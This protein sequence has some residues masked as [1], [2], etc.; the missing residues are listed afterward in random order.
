M[1]LRAF[2]FN[3]E[4]AR[5][6][7]RD[8]SPVIAFNFYIYADF[9]KIRHAHLILLRRSTDHSQQ[10]CLVRAL[11]SPFALKHR[12]CRQGSALRRGGLLLRRSALMV[13]VP[14]TGGPHQ[15]SRP[16]HLGAAP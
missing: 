13:L 2:S 8:Y 12:E 1:A 3:A 5:P 15:E 11:L 16:W 4:S 9:P 14:P 6:K 7:L 10:R